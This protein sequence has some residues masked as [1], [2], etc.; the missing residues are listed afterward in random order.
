MLGIIIHKRNDRVVKLLSA[1][2]RVR[3]KSNPMVSFIQKCCSLGC[4]ENYLLLSMQ[5]LPKADHG[6]CARTIC[7]WP[8]LDGIL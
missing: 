6:E 7:F 3:K 8:K 1:L 2:E 5:L 4:L